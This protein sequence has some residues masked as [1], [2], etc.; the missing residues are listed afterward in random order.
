MWTGW[1]LSFM[2]YLKKKFP[3]CQGKLSRMFFRPSQSK[4]AYEYR[5]SIALEWVERCLHRK[6]LW[7]NFRRGCATT[8]RITDH[9]WSSRIGGFQCLAEQSGV[10][11]R[12]VILKMI[13]KEYYWL[14]III[15]T[16]NKEFDLHNN[17]FEKYHYKKIFKLSC[18]ILI[19]TLYMQK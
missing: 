17:C 18:I 7:G 14:F 2:K 16:E 11:E 1:N 8:V 13:K 9:R 10:K 15:Q 6:M 4:T 5:M 3:R 12:I 19:S